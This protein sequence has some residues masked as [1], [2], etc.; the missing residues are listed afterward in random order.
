MLGLTDVSYFYYLNQSGVYT[1]DG[2]DDVKEYEET[3]VWFVN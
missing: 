3:R 1:V 2:I